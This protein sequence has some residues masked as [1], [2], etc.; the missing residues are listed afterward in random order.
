MCRDSK[1]SIFRIIIIFI[2]VV[3][4]SAAFLS[5]INKSED[6]INSKITI[7]GQ[8][9]YTN[10]LSSISSITSCKIDMNLTY[11]QGVLVNQD[12]TY[13]IYQWNWKSTRFVDFEKKR[14]YLVMNS[15]DQES[16]HFAWEDYLIEGWKYT[17]DKP[18]L[19]PPKWAKYKVETND[20][21][22][23]FAKQ[24]QVSVFAEVLK[25]ATRVNLIGLDRNYDNNS[26]ILLIKPSGNAIGNWVLSQ[27]QGKGLTFG[28]NLG[29][30]D[31]ANAL[32]DSWIEIFVDTKSSL[33]SRIYFKL[34][35]TAGRV[36]DGEMNFYS[37][38]EPF[39]ID[40]PIDAQN[41]P[42][43]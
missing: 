28:R 27:D 4:F 17:L 29:V 21:N 32:Q 9:I 38:N 36:F 34:L 37:Y 15:E 2:T 10:M 40:V 43:R 18:S 3:L 7:Q 24:A 6:S 42:E 1:G 31:Y 5:C 35:L 14:L 8:Q 22:K 11:T 12:D 26:H 33:I 41:A 39:T 25:S 23:L 30:K 16:N 13:D 20:Y 19:S